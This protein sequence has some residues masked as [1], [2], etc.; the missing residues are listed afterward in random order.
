M[1]PTRKRNR[2]SLSTRKH[3]RQRQRHRHQGGEERTPYE[4]IKLFSLVSMALDEEKQND[5]ALF[6]RVKKDF[7]KDNIPK[8]KS[9]D[10]YEL[11]IHTHTM[12][13]RVSPPSSEEIKKR[14]TD[15]HKV[16]HFWV[17]KRR[18]KEEKGS[19][20]FKHLFQPGARLEKLKDSINEFMEFYRFLQGYVQGKNVSN[21]NKGYY[22][23][24]L[25]D[26]KI[27][28]EMMGQ[29]SNSL[30]NQSRAYVV[31]SA[32]NIYSF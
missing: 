22:M 20:G 11:V 28:L 29:S 14:I 10:W 13:G 5:D 31:P 8:M 7:Y 19:F 26:E 9:A 4:L 18:M 12:P 27:V 6:D 30:S 17:Q 21:A 15:I 23:Q 32:E 25:K 16:L 1:A 3:R 24:L 2:R